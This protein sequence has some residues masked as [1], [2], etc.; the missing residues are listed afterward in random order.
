[1]SVLPE[2]NKINVYTLLNVEKHQ[3]CFLKTRAVSN[4]CSK[5][6]YIDRSMSV[7]PERDKINVYILLNVEKHQKFFLKTRADRNSCSKGNYID[8]N[9][10]VLP[11]TDKVNVYILRSKCE[12]TPDM[13]SIKRVWL[14]VLAQKDKGILHG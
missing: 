13:L 5:G 11:E 8:R 1:M 2:T 3:K 14:K 7:L 10:S 12:R 9:M 4:S 6:N